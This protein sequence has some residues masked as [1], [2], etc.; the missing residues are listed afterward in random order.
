MLMDEVWSTITL[1]VS[2]L[3]HTHILQSCEMTAHQHKLSYSVPDN[4]K[5]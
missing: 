2:S 5:M 4:D 3:L 1:G